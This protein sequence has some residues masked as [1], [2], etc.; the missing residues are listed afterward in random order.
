MRGEYPAV[1][2]G[3][4][5]DICLGKMLDQ[6]KNRGV[7]KKYL[8]NS[9][10]RWGYF[11]LADLSEMKFEDNESDRY[12][13]IK[14]DLVICEGGE[15]GRCAIWDDELPNMMIQKALHRVRAKEKNLLIQYLYYWLIWAGQNHL[16][17]AYFTGTTIKHLTGRALAKIQFPLPHME[18]Q[19]SIAATLSC[20]D[21]KIELNNRIITNLESQAQ[22]IFKSWLVDFEPFQDGEFE[23]SELGLIPKG[24]KVGTLKDICHYSN[25]R[26]AVE[27]LNDE[28]YIST[29][30]MLPNKQ[31]FVKA[32]SLPTTAY[33][34]AYH[35][36]DVLISNIRPYF[37]KIVFCYGDG[38]CSTDVICFVVNEGV[39]S[40]YLFHL[41]YNDTFF[42]F[43]V[44][45]SKGTK[46]PRGDKQQLMQYPVVQPDDKWLSEFERV[47]Q[48]MLLQSYTLKQ[49]NERL[50]QTRDTLLPKLMSGKIEVPVEG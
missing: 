30:N 27:T 19:S 24:W 13:I 50:A 31:G 9:N 12:G 49:E 17:E 48:P 11:D 8:G 32:T 46:M 3:D 35:S 44:G 7:Y 6:K 22:A 21:D 29:E 16:L 39:P 34:T 15:P 23:E 42:D 4:V 26:V 33:T 40:E 5:C 47:A 14:G 2:I 45:G 20:L 37:K 1:L 43:M 18:V 28:I 38:G 10:V 36:G 41:L 25:D